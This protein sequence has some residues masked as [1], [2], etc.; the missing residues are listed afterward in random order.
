M[1]ETTH[2]Q[3]LNVYCDESCHLRNDHQGHMGFGS[4]T[5]S[6]DTVYAHAQA[7]RRIKKEYGCTGEL[8]WTK[9]SKKNL[10]FY[11]ALVE[12]FF[13]SSDLN[14]RALVV[15]DKERLD[16]E[17]FNKG[18]HDLFYYKMYY[19]LIRGLTNLHNKN[20]L[21]IYLDIKDT[22]GALRVKKLKKVLTNYLCDFEQKR[23]PRIQVIRSSES[24]IL[25]LTDFLLG[26]LM[27]ATRKLDT[28]SAKI[29]ITQLLEE[30]AGYSLT[31]ST[32]PWEVKFNLFHFWPRKEV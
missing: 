3:I 25:Q 20:P 10:L 30:K 9:V 16:H 14:F 31:K 18:S 27:Y 24:E 23:I 2:N 13:N 6:V 32:E 28:S 4:I 15:H 1:E 21:H 8:K 17:A 7:I 26:A 11:T 29:H 19:F 12:Y 22:H 5:V